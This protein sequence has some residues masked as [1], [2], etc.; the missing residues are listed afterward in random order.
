MGIIFLRTR[1]KPRLCPHGVIWVAIKT[2]KDNIIVAGCNVTSFLSGPVYGAT[3]GLVYSARG[4]MN[5]VFHLTDSSCSSGD[6]L[7]TCLIWHLWMEPFHVVGGIR[8]FCAFIWR[9]C[10]L[11]L[12]C[13][14]A[15]PV[16]WMWPKL[17][18]QGT[19]KIYSQNLK[20]QIT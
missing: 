6:V 8:C 1:R 3:S 20:T 18:S 14:C 4:L 17:C 9:I 5:I 10:V 12:A 7:L 19:P 11:Y 13:A 15:T 16:G 2:G